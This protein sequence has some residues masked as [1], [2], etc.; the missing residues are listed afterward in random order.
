MSTLVLEKEE[1][2]EKEWV[3]KGRK[4]FMAGKLLWGGGG[5]SIKVLNEH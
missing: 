4:T 2:T 3:E 5:Q 1:E